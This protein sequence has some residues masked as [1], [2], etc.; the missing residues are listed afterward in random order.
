VDCPNCGV[1]NPEERDICWRCDQ[2]LPKPKERNKRR[3][4][5]AVTMRRVWIIV[6]LAVL[7]W[8]LLSFVLPLF[9]GG[10]VTTPTP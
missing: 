8:M 1:Y 7:I 9:F 5:P 6:A 4:D 3:A 10:P 2:P